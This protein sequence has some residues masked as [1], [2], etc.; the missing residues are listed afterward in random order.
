[1]V[2]NAEVIRKP[3][4]AFV[5]IGPQ[6]GWDVARESSAIWNNRIGNI[7]DKSKT[8]DDFVAVNA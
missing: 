1:M 6:T 3:F 4:S 7:A 8:V 5:L 2:A